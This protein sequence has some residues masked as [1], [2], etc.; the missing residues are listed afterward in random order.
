MK[1]LGMKL[2]MWCCV[3]GVATGADWP[4]WR[5]PGR[6]GVSAE[7]GWFKEGASARMVWEGSV[8]AGYSAVAIRGGKLYTAGNRDNKDVVVC[9]EARTGNTIWK[10]SYDCPAGDYPGP[11][12]TPATDSSSVYAVSRQG[13]VFCLDSASG[14][15]RWQRNLK[16]DLNVKLPGWGIAGSPVVEGDLLLL[17]VGARGMALDRKTGATKWDSGGANTGY[18]S[19]V[20]AG[21]GAGRSV[22]VFAAKQVVASDLASGRQLWEYPWS[23]SYDVNAADPVVVDGNVFIT[24]GYDRG[25]ALLK[26][27]QG[28]PVVAWENKSMGSHFGTPVLR[29]GFAYG[30]HGNTGRGSIRCIEVATGSVKWE[31]A[32]MSYGSLLLAGDKLLIQGEKGVLAVTEATPEQYRELWQGKVLDG[33]CWTMPTLSDGLVYCR[34]DKGRLVCL[35]LKGP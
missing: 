3:A 30:G 19:P 29:K 26:M 34:N 31:H 13:Q 28:A 10:F 7:T 18:S 12:S 8:G 5:G 25:G 1:S 14:E 32:G 6:D 24:S 22:I 35:D 23:T 33:I 11:R 9:L 16:A 4:Q 20:V 17:N 27:Q 15:C 2:A 21:S